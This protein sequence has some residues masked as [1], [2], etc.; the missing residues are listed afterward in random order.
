MDHEA[1]AEV[2][3]RRFRSRW[4]RGYSKSK[5]RTDPIFQV[6]FASLSTTS[7]TIYDIGCGVGLLPF[8]LR[9]RGFSGR[10]VGIDYDERKIAA[11]KEVAAQY[12]SGV[13]FILGDA[14]GVI[15]E[16]GNIVMFDVLHYMPPAHQTS[17]LLQIASM[18][19]RG[20]RTMIRDGIRDNSFRYW[21]TWAEERFATSIGWLR[22]ETLAFPTIEEIA[23]PFRALGCAEDIRLLSGRMPFNNYM[24]TFDRP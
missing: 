19:G 4:L 5:I 3:S 16:P 20:C 8:Y 21:M 17:L 14:R 9:E 23:G 6:A 7:T 10:V 11:A 2:V 12:D 18:T 22:G 15:R 24:L 1:A 13:E